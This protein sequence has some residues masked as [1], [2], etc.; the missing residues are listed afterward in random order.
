L[1]I[2]RCTSRP[3]IPAGFLPGIARQGRCQ[4][5]L[6]QGQLLQQHLAWTVLQAYVNWS[7]SFRSVF[8]LFAGGLTLGVSSQSSLAG[9]Q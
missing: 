4:D 5:A 3:P 9:F 7:G 8:D 1:R 2:I 6:L